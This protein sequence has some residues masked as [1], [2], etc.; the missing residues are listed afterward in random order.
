[1]T[2]VSYLVLCA[3]RRIVFWVS[4]QN[5]TMKILLDRIMYE[6]NVSVRQLEIR[7]G[8]PRSTIADIMNEKISPRLNTMEQLAK[9]LGCRMTDLFDSEYK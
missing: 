9:A 3:Q 1:M 5:N 7:S 2:I 8:V 6:K 4:G